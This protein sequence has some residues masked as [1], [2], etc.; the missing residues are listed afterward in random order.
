MREQSFALREESPEAETNCSEKM[1][2]TQWRDISQMLQ[3][4]TQ[5]PGDPVIFVPSLNELRSQSYVL[6]D[7]F[8]P[9]SMGLLGLSGI[10]ANLKNR[11]NIPKQI[12]WDPD[13]FKV[14]LIIQEKNEEFIKTS[15]LP[16]GTCLLICVSSSQTSHRP[17]RRCLKTFA[18]RRCLNLKQYSI[19]KGSCMLRLGC[20][21]SVFFTFGFMHELPHGDIPDRDIQRHSL[22]SVWGMSLENQKPSYSGM[23][24]TVLE[25]EYVA[26]GASSVSS[27]RQSILGDRSPKFFMWFYR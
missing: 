3:M 22:E 7:Q 9:F 17:G 14:T 11:G 12:I 26:M 24:F 16:P 10:G 13:F 1:L 27:R 2:E 6:Q 23:N 4:K 21:N 15:S 25:N 18:T 20:E 5:K 19:N 8:T